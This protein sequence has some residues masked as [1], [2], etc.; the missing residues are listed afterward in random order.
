MP[1][2][3]PGVGRQFAVCLVLGTLPMCAMTNSNLCF[4]PLPV[5]VVGSIFKAGDVLTIS[6]NMAWKEN[7]PKEVWCMEKCHGDI[8]CHWTW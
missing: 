8:H 6:S 5:P 1:L 4:R 2:S 3:G 7:D